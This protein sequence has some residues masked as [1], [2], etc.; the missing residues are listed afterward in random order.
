[1]STYL[2]AFVVS[3]FEFQTGIQTGN[4]VKFQ[5]WSRSEALNQTKYAADIGP[6]ILQYYEDYFNVDFPL[7]KQVPTLV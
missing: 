6:R 4:N 7:P 5:I 2:L 3:D 1:M